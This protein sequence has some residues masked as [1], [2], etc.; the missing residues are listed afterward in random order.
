MTATA[1]TTADEL[2]RLPDD[3]WRYELVRGELKRR[4]LAGALEGLIAARLIT[5]VGRQRSGIVLAAAGFQISKNPD[6]V[7]APDVAFVRSERV[8][9]TVAF[10]DGPPDL[11]FEVTSPGDTY[12]GIEEKTLGWLRAGVRAVVVVDPRTAS[13][14]IHRSSGATTVND[15][16]EIEDVIPGWKLALSEVFA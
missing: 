14:R 9:D 2:L 6:T 11:A 15:V 4:P 8:V 3:G 13:V 5:A 7:R 1:F 10:F 16:I 12:S